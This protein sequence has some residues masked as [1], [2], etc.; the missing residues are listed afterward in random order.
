MKFLRIFLLFLA[1]A[2]PANAGEISDFST[3]AANNTNAAY[4]HPEG[5]AP[6]S[7]N[8]NMREDLAILARW[9]RDWRGSIADYGN[10]DALRITPNRTVSSLDDGL[11]FAFEVNATNT[12]GAT[13]QVGTLTAK[14]IKKS[15]DQNLVANDLEAGQKIIVIYDKSADV[16][17][18]VSPVANSFLSDPMT[19]RGD[20]IYRNS[21]NANARLAVG[22]NNQVIKSDGT[23]PSWGASPAVGKQTVWLP[24]A[25]CR[26]T[27]S[28]GAASLA[29]QETTSGRPD[30]TYL[31]FDASSDEHCQFS[32]AF[33]EGWNESTLTYQVH[34][35]QA[36]NDNGGVSWGLQAVSIT[37]NQTIDTAYG[38]AIVID[39]TAHATTEDLMVSDESGALTVTGAGT[40]ELAYFR[41][42]RDVSDTN[43]TMAADAWFIGLKLFYT[44][45]AANDN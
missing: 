35:S 15:N 4:G 39:D 37:D 1:L 33:P 34:W 7:V 13:L 28:N 19:T 29:G 43:D 20:L 22:T 41:L 36:S 12:T 25:A 3:T 14:T 21:S 16:F 11:H 9:Y 10:A 30:I 40:K 26:P 31:A 6:S 18:L 5:M 44:T 24:A 2:L 45:D 38:T 27:A 8:N 42:F 32:I 23:D 17:Q